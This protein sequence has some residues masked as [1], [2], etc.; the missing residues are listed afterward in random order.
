MKIVI[1]GA[2]SENFGAGQIVDVLLAPELRG[3]GTMLSLVDADGPR[4]RRMTAL[5]RRV[6]AAVGS[7]ASIEAATDRRKALAGAN[8]V[9]VAVAQQ[10][11]PLWEQDY[12]IPM[13]YGF[14]HVLGENGGPG[15]IFHALRSLELMM[16][17]CRDIESLCPDAL[18][19]NFT[20]P[21]CRVLHAI[22]HLTKVRAIGLCHGVFSVIDWL[23]R[24]LKRPAGGLK[25]ISAGINHLYCVLMATDIRTGKELLGTAI[26]KAAADSSGPHL[27][28]KFAE[29]FGVL[30]FPSDDHIGEYVAWGHE[31]T[32]GKWVYG[33]ERRKVRAGSAPDGASII[34]AY[35]TGQRPID[36][37]LLHP[38]GEL[39]IPVICDI[40]L[41]RGA[42]RPAVNVLNTEGYID[43]L[44]RGAAVEV[45]ATANARGVHPLHVGS[46][47]EAFAAILRTQLAIVELVTE[48]YRTRSRKLLLQALLLDPCV[49]SL[50]AA[51]RMLDEMLSLQSDYLPSFA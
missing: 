8:Y 21:E 6:K 29:V 43:N 42:F 9:I 28:R 46:I 1:V 11:Y 35:A 37:H 25:V 30:T 7:D 45:P 24:T 47:P 32:A 15:A 38:S 22:G 3:R 44:P 12:R 36:A 18:M 49:N 51:E 5:A 26:R 33:Q 20:N 23:A 41:D 50:P 40:E 4:L 19:M 2:G 14:R 13:A 31:A 48:A 10:R 27:F 34:Q 17:I 39:A 16:P